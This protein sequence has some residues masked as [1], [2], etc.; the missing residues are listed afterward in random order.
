MNLTGGWNSGRVES[1]ANGE[2]YDVFEMTMLIG[3]SR[4]DRSNERIKGSSF[5]Q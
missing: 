2:V 4:K 5:I 1:V 3:N